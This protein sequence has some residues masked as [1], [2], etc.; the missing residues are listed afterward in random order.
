M[1]NIYKILNNKKK[2]CFL[3]WKFFEENGLDLEY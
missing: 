2:G 1:L 3:I